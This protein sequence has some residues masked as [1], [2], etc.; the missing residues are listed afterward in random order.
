MRS[1]AE[2]PLTENQA[3]A[4]YLRDHCDGVDVECSICHTET[5]QG[6]PLP[7]TP[8]YCTGWYDD[9]CGRELLYRPWFEW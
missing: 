8:E 2:G 6:G 4:L 7:E 1:L 5:R 3:I 9:G